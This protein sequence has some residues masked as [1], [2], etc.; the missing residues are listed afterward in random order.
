MEMAPETRQRIVNNVIL[1]L[2]IFL[3]PIVLMFITF[4][5]TGDRPWE[6]QQKKITNLSVN[7]T[8]NLS[9]NGSND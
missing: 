8:K 4:Y 9:N 6:K 1:S 5:F 7:K 2:F 3:L